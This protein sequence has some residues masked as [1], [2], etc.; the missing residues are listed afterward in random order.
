MSGCTPHAFNVEG[1]VLDGLGGGLGQDDAF[2]I[3]P[4]GIVTEPK[5]SRPLG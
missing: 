5:R 2:H 1:D 3:C 4:F